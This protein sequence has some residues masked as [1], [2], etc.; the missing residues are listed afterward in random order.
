MQHP[1]RVRDKRRLSRRALIIILC[2][3]LALSVAL[4]LLLPALRRD[5]ATEAATARPSTVVALARHDAATLASVTITPREGAE[6]TLVYS[7]GALRLE[8]GGA[9]LDIREDSSKEII[10][11]VTVLTAQD[12][13][14][15]DAAELNGHLSEMGLEPPFAA[16]TARYTDGREELIEIGGGV[17]ET[18]YSYFRWSGDAGIYMCDSGVADAL[19]QP[20]DR[21]LPV[22]VPELHKALID[23]VTLTS[24][25]GES[26]ELRLNTAD[27]G[28]VSGYM[29]S[30]WKYPVS[31]EA[32]Q[33]VM[34]AVCGVALGAPLEGADDYGFESPLC[35]I[36]AHRDEGMRTT[37][38]EDGQLVYEALPE[39]SFRF[40][41]GR[42]EGEYYYTCLYEGEGF[43]VS[44]LLF[45]PLV[46]VK[47]EELCSRA[48]F[49]TGAELSALTVRTGEGVLDVRV[50]RTERVLPNNELETDADG[51]VVYDTA[52]TING[53][54]AAAE[55]YDALIG[56]LEAITVSGRLPA[57]WTAQGKTP[58][59]SATLESADGEARTLAAYALDAFSD[60][61]VVDGTALYYLN[62]EALQIGLGEWTP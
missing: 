42:E 51:S 26:I 13:V 7:D 10:E 19:S 55:Q 3:L 36:E 24:S 60:A 23:N 34:N 56:R 29:L 37:I 57:D 6:Y 49:V 45:S 54:A 14:A 11:A 41:I 40:V 32:A 20:S 9:L 38:A 30:P 18:S 61:L 21:L 25:A 31:A 4:V 62:I 39:A 52:I 35:V 50:R 47:A 58:R 43:L 12:S 46:G 28:S 48:P 15:S 8:S 33:T 2:A 22:P 27:D 5:A 17:P 59:W 1:Q 16:A 44:R 53:E